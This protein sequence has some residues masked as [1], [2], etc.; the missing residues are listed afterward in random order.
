M[1]SYY[2][3]ARGRENLRLR[4]VRYMAALKADRFR[5]MVNFL[6]P[7]VQSTGDVLGLGTKQGGRGSCCVLS[8]D[9]NIGKKFTLSNCFFSVCQPQTRDAVP[10]YDE[11]KVMFSACDTFTQRMPDR[12]F[13]CR[14]PKDTH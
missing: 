9:K 5:S 11:Y 4:Q 6:K 3:D 7:Q 8:R 1:D 13:P 14:L 10:I 12:T 2:L